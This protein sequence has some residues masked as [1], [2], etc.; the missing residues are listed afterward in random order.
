MQKLPPNTFA[1]VWDTVNQKNI[2]CSS[3]ILRCDDKFCLLQNGKYVARKYCFD[4]EEEAKK[5]LNEN[6]KLS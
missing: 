1:I 3:M 4:S 6:P 2:I 5:V